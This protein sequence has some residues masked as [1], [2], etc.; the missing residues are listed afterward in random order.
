MR[1][2]TY[3]KSAGRI[4]SPEIE[5]VK[6]EDGREWLHEDHEEVDYDERRFD[7]KP[8]EYVGVQTR[9]DNELNAFIIPWSKIASINYF[10]PT[11]KGGDE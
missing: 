4:H 7:V 9:D 3:S 10:Y 8:G 11:F 5:S 1:S 6:H 2:L